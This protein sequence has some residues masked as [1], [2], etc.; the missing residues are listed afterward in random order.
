[1]KILIQQINILSP[2]SSYNGTCKDVLLLNGT[3]AM[4][5]DAGKLKEDC[6]LVID[7]KGKHLCP[8]LLDLHV[9]FR[10][11]GH[12]HKED[13]ISGCT[14]AKQGGFTGVLLMPSTFPPIHNRSSIEFINNRTKGELVD[15]FPA[16]T[17]SLHQ[18]GIDL[19]EMYDMYN[20][21]T[22]I[23]TDDKKSVQ[24]TGLMLRALLYS[25]NFNGKIFAYANDKSLSSRGQMHEGV[26]ST[27][28]GLRGIPPIAEEIMISRDLILA[29]YTDAAIHFSTIST[30]KSVDLI[31][32]AK[33][34]GIKVSAD[35]SVLNLSLEDT[36]VN[37]YDANFKVMPPLRDQENISSLIEGL[38]DG[39]IDAICSDH[40]PEDIENKKK[41]FELAAFGAEGLETCLAVAYTALK[42]HLSTEQIIEKLSNG[43]RKVLGLKPQFISEEQ[44]AN[45][46]IFD[47]EKTWIVNEKDILSKSKNNPFLG[48]ELSGK[49]LYVFNKDHVYKCQ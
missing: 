36:T 26:A 29:E 28:L 34:K 42:N 45:L 22:R 14:A 18:D 8:G 1:M 4:I 17:I 19:S 27:L 9:N 47:F 7:G 16:G 24:D 11:P 33:R 30:S 13:L 23:F 6:D 46:S 40:L 43:P 41:E 10:E 25:K 38:K 2:G 49:A 35:V 39:T 20:A 31:R 37:T 3:I 32:A 5:K 48:K 44:P 12:E 21:G 15:V